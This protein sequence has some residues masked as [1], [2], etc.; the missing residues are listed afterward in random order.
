[1]VLRNRDYWPPGPP[2]SSPS[3]PLRPPFPSS[4]SRSRM[5]DAD[6]V[7]RRGRGDRGAPGEPVDA[8]GEAGPGPAVEAVELGDE[9]EHLAARDVDAGRQ[10]GDPLAEFVEGVGRGDGRIVGSG[11]EGVRAGGG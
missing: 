8:R 7:A 6:L 11:A 4:A 2:P 10:F 3:P 9:E 5:R 1:M